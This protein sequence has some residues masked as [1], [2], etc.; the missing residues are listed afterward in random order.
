MARRSRIDDPSR[1]NHSREHRCRAVMDEHAWWNRRELLEFDVEPVARVVG[2]PL[3][4]DVSPS[5]LT[6]LDAGEGDGH[7]LS[8]LGSLDLTVVHLHAS[9]SHIAALRLDAQDVAAADS[10]GPE[11]AGCDGADPPQREHA[12]DVQPRRRL[13]AFGLHGCA[14]K[15]GPKLV[16]PRTRL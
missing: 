5:D 7:P 10:P 15:R 11:R 3:D 2:A 12:V 14:C 1:T 8:G 6:T 4:E 9:N 13:I 16:Q